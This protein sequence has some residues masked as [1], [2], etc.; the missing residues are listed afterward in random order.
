MRLFQATFCIMMALTFAFTPQHCW[1]QTPAPALQ[2][3]FTLPLAD[4]TTAKAVFLPTADS[5]VWLVYATPTGQIGLW[6]MQSATG[7]SPTPPPD[8]P[9]P[10]VPPVPPKPTSVSVITITETDQAPCPALVADYLSS[11]RSTYYAFTIAMVAEKNPPANSLTW[12]GRTAGKSYPYS[13]VATLEGKT[14]WEG[15]TPKKDS[16]FIAVIQKTITPTSVK[17]RCPGTFCPVEKVGAK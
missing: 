13:F 10:P 12:I 8:P 11:T 17:T 3:Q 6:T 7:P 1:S 5:K 9:V 14:L 4:K 16:D 15:P 2:T